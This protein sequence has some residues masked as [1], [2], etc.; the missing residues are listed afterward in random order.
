MS[1]NTLKLSDYC[2]DFVS[3][4]IEDGLLYVVVNDSVSVELKQE[5]I[6]KLKNFLEEMFPSGKTEALADI[7]CMQK[8]GEDLVM[9]SRKLPANITLN[10]TG[11]VTI[12]N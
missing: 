4:E 8:V 10:V 3:F 6:L 5:D 12:N 9:D 1:Q 7:A 11:N 2:D